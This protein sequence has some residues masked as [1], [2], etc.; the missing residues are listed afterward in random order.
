MNKPMSTPTN[1]Q[2][3]FVIAI[4][5]PAASGKGTLARKLAEALGFAYMDTGAL[6]RAV[7]FEVLS[8][9]LSI[10]D[11]KDARDAAQI[12]VKKIGRARNPA[13]ILG[14]PSLR[15]DKIG[16][17][18]S[19]VAAMPEVREV[20]LKLQRDFAQKPGGSYLGAILDG[21]D[22]GTVICPRA[23]VK[24]FITAKT[25][26]RAERRLKELQSKGIAVTYSTVLSEMLE[27]DARDSSRNAAPMK[28]ADDAVVIDSSDMNADQLLEKALS[29]TKDRLKL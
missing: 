10:K 21:R 19:V 9:G 17:A 4:D 12:L 27:R 26:I 7:A 28:P 14:K 24:F 18:A 11:K 13:D 23:D 25:E 1:R 5:G 8:T 16:Q 3:R 29:V 6:Y 15:E 2:E 22:I 20:L